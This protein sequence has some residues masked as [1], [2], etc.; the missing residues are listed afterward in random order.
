MND[1]SLICMR[2]D[3]QNQEPVLKSVRPFAKIINLSLENFPLPALRVTFIF[4]DFF[5]SEK[6]YRSS[7]IQ[8]FSLKRFTVS[9]T[10][11]CLYETVNN[12]SNTNNGTLEFEIKQSNVMTNV[13]KEN[14]NH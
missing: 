5:V 7:Y 3:F 14:T 1:L 6:S 11:I 4:L 8:E 9:L 12:E 10:E 13:I 2:S